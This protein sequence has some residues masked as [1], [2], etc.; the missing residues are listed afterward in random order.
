[1]DTV[2]TLICNPAGAEMRYQNVARVLAVLQG[3]TRRFVSNTLHPRAAVDILIEEPVSGHRKLAEKI[4]IALEGAR[5]DVVVQPAQNRRKRLFVADMDSTIIEQECIDELADFAGKRA[6]IAAITERAMRG[7]LDFEAALIERVAM[8]KG[9]PES[10][11]AEA[12]EKRITLTPGAETLV[13]IMKKHGAVTALVSGGF[14]FF[15]ARVAAR[16]GFDTHEANT[17]IVENGR[18]TGEVASPIKG[19][20]AKEEALVR[21]AQEHGVSLTETLA[22]GDGANDLSMLARA[23]L[24]VAFRAKPAVAEAASARIDHGDLT[25]LLYLQGYRESDVAR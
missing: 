4:R 24:G 5:V 22:V 8:L 21:L 3:E 20:A 14:T 11:L 23:G 13:R 19:R 17:L 18:L 12:A 15:T 7:E 25:A 9:L 1:M 10:A 16:A 6:E 2:V